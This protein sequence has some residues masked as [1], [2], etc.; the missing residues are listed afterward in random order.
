MDLPR[1]TSSSSRSSWIE[2]TQGAPSIPASVVE[3]TKSQ[4]AAA[5]TTTVAPAP[6]AAAREDINLKRHPEVS[7]VG[8]N[9]ATDGTGAAAWGDMDQAVCKAAGEHN[10]SAAAARA[11]GTKSGIG[12]ASSEATAYTDTERYILSAAAEGHYRGSAGADGVNGAGDGGMPLAAA[13]ENEHEQRW[14][15]PQGEAAA[16]TV[17]VIPPAKPVGSNVNEVGPGAAEAREAVHSNSSSSR[18]GETNIADAGHPAPTAATVEAAA[19]EVAVGAREAPIPKSAAPTTSSS[20]SNTAAGYHPSP[21]DAVSATSSAGKEEGAEGARAERRSIGLRQPQDG[22]SAP[23]LFNPPQSPSAVSRIGVPWPPGGN[24][25]KLRPWG[26]FGAVAPWTPS[27]PPPPLPPPPPPS[28]PPLQQ[29]IGDRAEVVGERQELSDFPGD[30]Q[31]DAA[32]AGGEVSIPGV[33]MASAPGGGSAGAGDTTLMVKTKKGRIRW[34]PKYVMVKA[35]FFFF[36]S[37]LG[38][39]MPYLPVYYHALSLP[40]R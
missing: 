16:A 37:S 25:R 35:V 8:T 24:V 32:T 17:A 14:E 7:N 23:S 2:A 9:Y 36:Y 26:R 34:Q 6:V 18:D 13:D 40:D 3:S 30:D 29:G 12:T 5:T 11:E 33:R 38:A 19:A 15:S 21:P 22:L 27:P 31:R 28:P 4:K 39:I 20:W 1:S 10:P